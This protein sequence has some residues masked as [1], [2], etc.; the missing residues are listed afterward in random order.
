MRRRRGGQKRESVEAK[1]LSLVDEQAKT[2]T[3]LRAQVG[4]R[5][6]QRRRMKSKRN[7]ELRLR[8]R[9]ERDVE[10]AKKTV[11]AQLAAARAELARRAE[12]DAAEQNPVDY[13]EVAQLRRELN[14]AVEDRDA[15]HQAIAQVVDRLE[16]EREL[17]HRLTEEAEQYESIL[18]RM[19]IKSEAM[20]TVFEHWD[21]LAG[22]LFDQTDGQSSSSDQQAVLDF[23]VWMHQSHPRFFEHGRIETSYADE[24]EEVQQ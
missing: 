5:T 14:E 21:F 15:A 6:G 13:V 1:L 8:R 2:I 11:G 9:A 17:T 3:Q 23:W 24:L 18:R 19:R 16:Q 7:A 12:I 20:F 4:E 10:Q 22:W